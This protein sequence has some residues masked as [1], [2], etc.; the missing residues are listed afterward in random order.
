K[1]VATDPR[2]PPAGVPPVPR[3]APAELRYL[4]SSRNL[5]KFLP[6]LIRQR[7]RSPAA[8]IDI[9]MYEMTICEGCFH[10]IAKQADHIGHGR[11]S[12]PADRYPRSDA[13]GK[14]GLGMIAAPGLDHHADQR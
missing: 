7:H 14:T 11:I 12:K 6:P 2:S 3:A 13:V 10:I 8:A 5:S 9:D 1:A 4:R